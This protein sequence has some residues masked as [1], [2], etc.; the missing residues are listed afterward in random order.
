VITVS[1]RLSAF[2]LITKL[3]KMF[4]KIKIYFIKIINL[5]MSS[6]KKVT[7]TSQSHFRTALK[8]SWPNNDITLKTQSKST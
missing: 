4:I 8:N 1:V 2:Q 5:N 6:Y 7:P 3:I